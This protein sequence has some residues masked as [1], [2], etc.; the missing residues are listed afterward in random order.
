MKEAEKTSDGADVNN[1]AR[2]ELVQNVY[3]DL[4]K[5]ASRQ[6]ANQNPGHTLTATALVNEVSV[7]L[8]SDNGLPPQD[9]SQ[10]L[11]Y[12]SRAMRNMLVDHARSKGRQKRGG[13][14]KFFSFHEAVVAAN[15]QSQELVQ[16]HDALERLAAVLPRKA[17]VVEMRY[18]GGMQLNEIAEALDI[19]V[20][21]VKRDWEVAKTMLL[22]ELRQESDE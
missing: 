9:R 1:V 15:E 8:L 14:N 18:F 19:S 5:L 21:T 17:Q 2:H 22:Q 10:F 13:E 11:S 4:R 7:K 3:E 16:L 12:A 6:M 20:A